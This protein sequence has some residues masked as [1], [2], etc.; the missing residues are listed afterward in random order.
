MIVAE[1]WDHIR[2][3]MDESNMYKISKSTE[4]TVMNIRDKSWLRIRSTKFIR[5]KKQANIAILQ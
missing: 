5:K 1:E 2:Q 4:R 3:K